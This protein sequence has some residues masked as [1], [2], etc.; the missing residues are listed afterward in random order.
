M[1]AAP[2]SYD[3]L[4]AAILAAGGESDPSELHGFVCG[5]LCAE[6]EPDS[7]FWQG[8][9]ARIL[10]LEA[11]PAALEN[12][13]ARLAQ[14]S[15]ERLRD[16]SFEFQLLLPDDSGIDVRAQSLG[17]WCQGFLHGLGVG[18]PPGIKSPGCREALQD[19]SEIAQIDA[20]AVEES[21]EAEQQL[22]QVQE[23]VRVAVLTIFTEI[24]QVGGADQGSNARG[25]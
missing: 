14:V 12:S 11:V 1:S 17:Q 4:S 20:L 6:K 13:M 23:Y 3:T 8:E 21:G 7:S 19:L 10:A 24:V 9:L 16:D 25:Q 22:L 15:A 2:P 5:L 18:A